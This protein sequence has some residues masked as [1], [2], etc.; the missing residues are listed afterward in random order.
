MELYSSEGCSSCPPAEK[1]MGRLLKDS[2]LWRKIIPVNFHVDYWNRLGWVDPYSNA[3]FTKRQRLYSLFWGSET[4]YTPAFVNNGAS[5]GASINLTKTGGQTK[6][7]KVPKL[8]LSIDEKNTLSLDTSELPKGQYE[9]HLVMLGNGLTSKIPAG[10]N[11]G[12]TLVQNFVVLDYKKVPLKKGKAHEAITK[13]TKTA[14][15]KS[16]SVAAWITR[17]GHPV[18]LQAVGGNL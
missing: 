9:A 10:E 3:Q 17:K 13:G 1:Q 6:L 5:I 14:K 16:Y 18:P 7:S 2:K 4:M 15:A 12:R 11:K 8:T